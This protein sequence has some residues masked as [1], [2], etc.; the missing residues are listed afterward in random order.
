MSDRCPIDVQDINVL[1]I[2]RLTEAAWSIT[3]SVL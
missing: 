3:D 1:T 2:F